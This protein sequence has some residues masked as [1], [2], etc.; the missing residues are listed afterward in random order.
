MNTEAGAVAGAGQPIEVHYGAARR[1]VREVV[2]VRLLR[3]P[4][5]RRELLSCLL[6][7]TAV[8]PLLAFAFWAHHMRRLARRMYAWASEHDAYC[9]TVAANLPRL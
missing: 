7:G 5:G 4:W 3:T 1:D 2:R 8:P 6:V 9:C